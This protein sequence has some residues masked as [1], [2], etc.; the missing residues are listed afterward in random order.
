MSTILKMY[1]TLMPVIFAGIANMVFCKSDLFQSLAFP[2]DHGKIFI[3]GKRMLGDNKTW[4]GFIGMIAFGIIFQIL[5]SLLFQLMPQLNQ[6]HY[7]YPIYGNYFKLNLY[8]GFL[9]GLAYVLF[10]LPN[11]FIKRRLDIPP[12]KSSSQKFLKV[13]FIGVDQAD[14]LI[15]CTLVIACFAPLTVIELLGFIFF[16]SLTHLIINSFLF[17]FKLRRNRF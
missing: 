11:S 9:L 3:D 6:W 10:E 5:W 8:L 12:G 4:K 2:M 15:G 14:S 16:G 17:Y 1:L 13:I 7:I